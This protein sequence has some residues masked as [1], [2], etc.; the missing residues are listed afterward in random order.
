MVVLV[1]CN[2]VQGLGEDIKEVGQKGEEILQ[3][4]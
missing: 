2:T 4:K 3:G 1:G